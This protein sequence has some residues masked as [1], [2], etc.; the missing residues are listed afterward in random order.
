MPN[1][2][3]GEPSE[4]RGGWGALTVDEVHRWR[5]LRAF[6]ELPYRLHAGSPWVPPVRIERLAY[7]NRKLNPF[8]THG[9]AAWFLARRQGTVVGR[10]SAQVDDEFNRFHG[11]R[12]GMFGF[13]ELEDDPEVA[14]ALL[15]AAEAWLRSEGCEKM[16]G[17][18]DLTVNDESGV[19]IEGFERRPQI[20]Q[21]WHPPYYQVR[22]EEAGLTKAVDLLSYEL[23]ISDREHLDPVIPKAA[24]RARS[25][26]GL[27]VRLMG[28]RHLRRDMDIFAEIYNDAWSD[29]W[30]FVPYGKADLD[31]YALE[32]QIAW[33]PGWFMIVEHDATPVA[34]AITVLDLNQVLARM[35]GRLL[36]WGWWYLLR[37]Y[38]Y[39]DQV[40]V[41]FLG[42]KPAYEYTGAAALLYAEHFA[43]AEHSW[44]KHGEAGWILETNRGM[45]RGLEAMGGRIV[46]RYRVYERQLA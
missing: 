15:A 7:L 42:V 39:V 23:D 21:P 27:T 40:R 22:C 17:P 45:R 6:V 26:H 31:A 8:F 19:L 38:H 44:I 14:E 35:H 32:M 34:M 41:G 1:A 29:N 2:T 36:P 11:S 3:P 16:V 4:Q 30:G 37:R 13:L 10:I 43:T 5:D 24:E 18:M 28:R 46:K 9:R 20:K 12:W 25:R 33:A